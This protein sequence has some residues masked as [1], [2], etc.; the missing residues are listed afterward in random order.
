MVCGE[1]CVPA[2]VRDTDRTAA[3]ADIRLACVLAWTH[4][5]EPQVDGSMFKR[6]LAVDEVLPRFWN[7]AVDAWLGAD[8]FPRV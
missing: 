5:F 4:Q 6:I 2:L 1:A 8:G 7:A 3:Y